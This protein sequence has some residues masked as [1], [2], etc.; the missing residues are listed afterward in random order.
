MDEYDIVV[1]GAGAVGQTAAQRAVRTGLS[2]ALVESELV[3]GED[4]FWA[5][6]PSKVLLRPGTVLGDARAVPGLD[7][8]E[9]DT[10]ATFARRDTVVGHW[11]DDE[12]MGWLRNTLVTVLRG[13]VRLVGEKTM[14]VSTADGDRTVVARHAVIVATG[15][16]PTIPDVPGLAQAR[17]WTSRDATSSHHVPQRLVVLGGGPAGVEATQAYQALGAQVTLLARTRRLLPKA[18][19]FVGTIMADAMTA[20]GVRVLTDVHAE[21]VWR[22]ASGVHVQVNHRGASTR[23]DADELLVVTGRHPVTSDLGL[24]T[25]GLT[26]GDP[27][28]I[29]SCGQVV[30][31]VGD[32]LYAVG[33]VTGLSGTTHHGQYHAR[34]AGDVVAARFGSDLLAR[35]AESKASVRY[36]IS[37]ASTAQVLCT[38][39]EV[40]WA[41]VTLAEARKARRMARVVDV[42]MSELPSAAV[43]G[44]GYEGQA[45]FVVD[46]SRQTVIGVTFVGPG[47]GEIIHAA[48]IA[49][50]A[51]VSLDALWHATPVHPTLSEVWG[52]FLSEYACC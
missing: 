30:G 37:S 23:V 38:R 28:P 5:S 45:R 6:R 22:D 40:A 16:E 48:T 29:D 50:A 15:S 17:F 1:V 3:G 18:E 34:V 39:P 21:R 36:R 25:I 4:A 2:V 51:E 24:E 19:P 47:V 14:S 33:D 31:V 43:R 42:D 44:T 13:M 12:E 46:A 52:R 11:R 49:V 27:L 41:G 10:D 7:A 32:W 20:A 26:P 8:G 9:V 35:V